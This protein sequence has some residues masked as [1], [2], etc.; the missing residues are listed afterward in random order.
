VQFL[1]IPLHDQAWLELRIR[2]HESLPI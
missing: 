1:L 2:D